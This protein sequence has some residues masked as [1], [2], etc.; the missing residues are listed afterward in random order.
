MRLLTFTHDGVTRTG[1]LRA[2][3]IVD[4]HGTDASV[5]ADMLSLLRGGD[6]MLAKAQA[7]A[8]SGHAAIALAEVKLE[9]PIPNPP[10]I[11]AIGLNYLAHWNE[12]PEELKKKRK[13]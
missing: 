1:A 5:P 2:E 6:A 10:R 7:A 13:T 4:L 8:E 12:I 3:H 11:L 9:S